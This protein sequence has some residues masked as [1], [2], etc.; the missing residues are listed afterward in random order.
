MNY[1][2]LFW[3][4]S[5]KSIQD[6]PKQPNVGTACMVESYNIGLAFIGSE[7]HIMWESSRNYTIDTEFV[8]Q[9]RKINAL[10]KAPLY[11]ILYA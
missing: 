9:L 3:T 4:D 5:I 11:K 10:Y 2:G 1:D 7:W 6:L 8:R